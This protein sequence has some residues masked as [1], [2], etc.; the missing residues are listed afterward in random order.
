M[1]AAPKSTCVLKEKVP[2]DGSPGYY[3]YHFHCTWDQ[4]DTMTYQLS[5]VGTDEKAAQAKVEQ[6]C[7]YQPNYKVGR[8]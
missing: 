3:T 8:A 4:G 5:T 7:P 2:V 6:D 1:A